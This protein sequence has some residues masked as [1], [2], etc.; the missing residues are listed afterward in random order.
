MTKKKSV[1]FKR[2]MYYFWK[3][4]MR[5]KVRTFLLLVLIPVYVF[6]SN[7]WLPRGTSDIVGQLASGDYEIA[8]YTALLMI[9]LLPTVLNN[10]FLVRVLDWLDW[11]LDAK[12]GEWLSNLAFNAVINQSMTFHSN[13]FSGSLTSQANKLPNAF[14][15]LKSQFVWDLP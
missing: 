10:L 15:Q 7:I 9:T 2:T 6:I 5:H 8:N 12:A 13:H 11:S 3:A 1:N 14:I 4:L